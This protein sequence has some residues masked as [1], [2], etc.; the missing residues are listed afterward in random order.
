MTLMCVSEKDQIFSLLNIG[1]KWK[2]VG[3]KTTDIFW[4]LRVE[5]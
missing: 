1:D 4:V 3:V 2:G 5:V